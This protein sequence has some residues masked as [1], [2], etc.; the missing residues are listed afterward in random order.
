[1]S[2]GGILSITQQYVI[3]R[4]FCGKFTYTS[5]ILQ[6][7]IYMRHSLTQEMRSSI[8]VVIGASTEDCW[9]TLLAVIPSIQRQT[10]PPDEIMLVIDHHRTL[11]ERTQ[12]VTVIDNE[13]SCGLSG[14][15]SSGVM[16]SPCDLIAFSG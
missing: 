7:Y 8:T 6:N 3:I 16:R 2:L 9:H 4:L 1:M 12:R 11:F 14:A 13:R 5:I 15:H 10:L